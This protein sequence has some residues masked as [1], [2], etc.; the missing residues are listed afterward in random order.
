MKALKE[1]KNVLVPTILFLAV[2]LPT[3]QGAVPS[4]ISYQGLLANSSTGAWVSDGNYNLHFALYTALTG[5]TKVWEEDTVGIPVEKGRFNVILGSTESL[6]NVPFD[7]PYWLSI[8]IN[9]GAELPRTAFTSSP[10]ALNARDI[11][12]NTVDST[13][14]KP[15][16][17]SFS[18]LGRNAA[19]SGQVPKW[20]GTVWQPQN[21]DVGGTGII[22]AGD[23]TFRADSGWVTIGSN[24]PAYSGA[25]LVY[26]SRSYNTA[27]GRTGFG[28]HV[29]NSL[30]GDLQAISASLRHTSGTANAS[31][32]V[33]SSVTSDAL[34]R[35]GVSSF[36]EPATSHSLSGQGY[37][38]YGSVDYCENAYGVY[39]T[40][41]HAT[42][43]YGVYGY[44][45]GNTTNWAGYFN[46]DVNVVGT[47]T[48][49]GGA[50]RIDH[51]LDPE[52]KFLQHSFVESPDMKNIYDGN[53]VTDASGYVTVQLP[54]YFES[55]NRDFRYQLTVIGDFAQAVISEKIHNNRFTIR[56]DKPN[57]EV[58]WQVTGIR[59]DRWAEANRIQVE[60]DKKPSE[61]GKYIYPTLYGQPVEQGIDW[62]SSH[63][64]GND[65]QTKK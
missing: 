29:E 61:R 17:I 50:F 34:Y 46:G 59:A 49:G 1:F 41:S 42:T 11:A 58:S 62:L 14:I 48:K 4:T 26:L 35:Y 65:R 57:M 24:F 15:A 7:V 39:G 30:G 37:G 31:I 18:D 63:S 21:D 19:S 60:V 54:D 53:V 51:P 25:F 55:L 13:K 33:S 6:V 27:S 47:L 56:T 32:G 28:A 43:G 2:F 38:V 22:S 10:Y 40:A 64:A 3:A 8:R 52:N 20:N 9:G 16:G 5:G 36:A 44:A 12:T 45:N 23:S